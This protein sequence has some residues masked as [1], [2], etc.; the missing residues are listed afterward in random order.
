MIYDRI[1]QLE[2]WAERCPALRR[3][4][5]AAAER[6]AATFEPGTV[7]IDGKALYAASS[8]YTTEA[9]E[10]R[11]FEH[12]RH[13][14]DVQMLVSGEE[15]IDVC[16]PRISLPAHEY[17][18]EGDIEFLP[19]EEAYSTVTMRAGEFLVLFPGEWHKPCV[20]TG[21]SPAACRKIV[22]K[23]DIEA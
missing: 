7:T 11:Q 22:M 2:V 4:L 16:L 21:A 8:E 6:F 9:R 12:H 5:L 3:A 15:Q 18:A 23:V 13:Y 10:A 1:D 14:I 19:L 17:K 20:S